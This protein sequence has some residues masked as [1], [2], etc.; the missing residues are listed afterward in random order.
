MHRHCQNG[1]YLITK[2][3]KRWTKNET[4]IRIKVKKQTK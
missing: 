1:W 3:S 4:S 2:M